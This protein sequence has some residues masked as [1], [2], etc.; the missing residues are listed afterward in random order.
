[1]PSRTNARDIAKLQIAR[2][3]VG[4]CCQKT[5]EALAFIDAGIEDVLLT[6]EVVAPAKLARLAAAARDATVG[7]LVDCA[8]GAVLASAA[9]TRA[10]TSLD[11][12]VEVDV[13]AGRCGVAPEDAGDLASHVIASRTSASQVCTA[14]TAPRSTCA[15]LKIDARRSPL[16]G[17]TSSGRWPRWRRSTSAAA[18]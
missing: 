7:L 6:N 3:A 2:G 12:Y 14:T 9:A 4:I 5:D 8:E 17:R 10:G 16:P 15:R 13:G 1:M 11:L 18:S